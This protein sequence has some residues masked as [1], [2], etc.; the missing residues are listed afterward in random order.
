MSDEADA[1]LIQKFASIERCIRAIEEYLGGDLSRLDDQ[2]IQDAV[3]LNVQRA[4]EQAIDAACRMV[5][6]RSLGVPSD[7]AAAFELLERRGLISIDSRHAMKA[8]VG[9]RNVAV[10]E[11]RRLDHA[12]LREVVSNRLGDFR[13]LCRELAEHA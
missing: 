13:R 1:V 10:H 2:L 3:L 5:S 9:F 12:I 6:K 11:Y 4:C 7:A 8:M